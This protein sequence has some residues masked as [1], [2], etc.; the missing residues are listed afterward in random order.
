[1]KKIIV[2][3]AGVAACAPVC[4]FATGF[5]SVVSSF[6]SPGPWP[7]GV[8][9]RPGYIYISCYVTG[10][11]WRTTTTGSVISYHPTGLVYNKGVTVG[12]VTGRIYYWVV[13]RKPGYIYRFVDNSSTV[14]GSFAVPGS[15]GWGVSYVDASHMYYTDFESQTLYLLHPMKGSIYSSYSLSFYPGD[16]AYDSTGYLWI[17]GPYVKTKSVF[18]CTLKGSVLASF[19]VAQ[20]GYPHGCG[21]DGEYVWVG[22]SDGYNGVYSIL[23]FNVREEPAVAPASLGKIKALYR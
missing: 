22:A 19:S 16:L 6:K 17:V 15:D 2:I 21:F 9:Y 11:I 13:N 3:V 8:A 7:E 1:M 20:Y 18:K 4:V 10:V 5:G 12:A 14:H 23:Q